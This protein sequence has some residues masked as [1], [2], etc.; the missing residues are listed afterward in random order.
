MNR[1][2]LRG[3]IRGTASRLAVNGN[4]LP[5]GHRADGLN[6]VL[7]A[8]LKFSWQEAGKDPTNGIMRGDAV[9]EVQKRLSPLLFRRPKFFDLRPPVCATHHSADRYGH[10]I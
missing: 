10:N 4:D 8:S 2:F 9:R 7:E 3:A 5:L 6:P 1:R